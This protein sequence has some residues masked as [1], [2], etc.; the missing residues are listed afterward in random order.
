M[1]ARKPGKAAS[2]AK[3]A[4]VKARSVTPFLWFQK[5]AEA[6]A[7][8]YVGLFQDARVLDANPMSVSFRIAGTDFIAFNGGPDLELNPAYSMFV[9]VDTQEQVDRLW[10]ALTEGGEESRCGW[11][12]DKFGLS[13]Q[14]IPKRLP[15]LLY[16]KDPEVAQRALQAMLTMRKIEVAELEAA[17]KGPGRGNEGRRSRHGTRRG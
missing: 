5:D 13:W 6:A 3:R 9:E 2:G 16:H 12:V 15:Q 14:I 4:K 8:F 1:A 11:L 7:R 10:A 17:A